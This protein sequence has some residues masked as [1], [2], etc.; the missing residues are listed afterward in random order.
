MGSVEPAGGEEQRIRERIRVRLAR[1]DVA[2]EKV[3]IDPHALPEAVRAPDVPPTDVERAEE[4]DLE[5][6]VA[7]LHAT[8]ELWDAPLRPARR[9]APF[10][11]RL[12]VAALRAIRPIVDRQSAVNGA[13]ARSVSHLKNRTAR[14]DHLVRVGIG[15]LTPTVRA[16]A[17]ALNELERRIRVLEEREGG[18][19]QADFNVYAFANAFRGDEHT[20]RERQRQYVELFSA[21][22]GPVL[23]FGCGRGEFLGLLRDAEISAVGVDMDVRMVEH[24]RSKGF[25]VELGDGFAYLERAP[26]GGLGGLFASQLIEHLELA[27]VIRL[28]RLARRGLERAG[29]NVL[30]THNPQTLLTYPAYAVDPTHVRLYHS[31]TV[32]WLLEQEGFTQREL[33]F[34][35]PSD[36]RGE[37]GEP[38]IHGTLEPILHGHL[39][40]AAVGR[41][42]AAA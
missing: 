16:Q 6:D 40:Y 19:R 22:T 8:Y 12:R 34:S 29:T 20:L 14:Q 25:T 32:A 15:T 2:H 31:D 39:T 41:A 42:P 36:G 27:G 17:K 18:G 9:A 4:E 37:S 38:E 7:T 26:A 30:E 24:A 21:A 28:L 10:V 5:R 33:R 35:D 1:R 3:D 11:Q 13:L 23:D